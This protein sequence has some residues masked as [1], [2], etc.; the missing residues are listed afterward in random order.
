VLTLA[1][2]P[3]VGSLGTSAA[4]ATT[5]STLAP[6]AD[7]EVNAA[8]QDHNYGA[9]TTLYT[10][11]SP[12]VRSYLRFNLAGVGG[13]QHATLRVQ[14]QSASSTGFQVKA[15]IGASWTESTVSYQTA[16]PLGVLVGSSGP[17]AA[18]AWSSV[19][20]T[21]LADFP[22]SAANGAGSSPAMSRIQAA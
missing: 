9:T 19:D 15:T 2:A 8:A 13:I 22:G 7:A 11:A 3:L 4:A 20:V 12:D 14:A 10:D 6:V 21:A 5:S 1:L 18:G 17:L 16:P